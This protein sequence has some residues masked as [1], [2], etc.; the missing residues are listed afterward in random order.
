MPSVL[1]KK[2]SKTETIAKKLWAKEWSLYD[3]AIAEPG[4]T[5]V[6][7]SQMQD[8]IDFREQTDDFQASKETLTAR[9]LNVIHHSDDMEAAAQLKAWALA[10]VMPDTI[11]SRKHKQKQLWI[12]GSTGI[13][14]SRMIAT[15]SH[16]VKVYE[17]PMDD[18]KWIEGYTH[19]IELAY[20]E[21]YQG[22][23]KPAWLN[24]FTDG[25]PC[26]L[27]R[28]NHAPFQKTKNCAV[29]VLSQD[30][31]KDVYHNIS[32]TKPRTLE[33]VE[34]RFLELHFNHEFKFQCADRVL[35][36]LGVVDLG[37][38]S[39]VNANEEGAPAADFDSDMSSVLSLD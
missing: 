16:F 3:A 27:P 10:N 9:M 37:A 26:K 39:V 7:K 18:G 21:E 8:W 20:F 22:G 17:V 6:H 25:S 24:N 15:L 4:Y 12:S 35:G 1:A 34:A 13:G 2:S 38:L 32:L 5:M 30:P 29:V 28:R 23:R 33:A 19:D 36:N 14:K 31:I 11:K